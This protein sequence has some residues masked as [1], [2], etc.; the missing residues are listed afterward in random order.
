VGSLKEFF[1]KMAAERGA[2]M[3]S[4][5]D[6]DMPRGFAGAKLRR[7]AIEHTLTRRHR[8][9]QSPGKGGGVNTPYPQTRQ[10][11]PLDVPRRLHWWRSKYMPH[12]GAQEAARRVRQGLC[13]V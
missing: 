2:F 1:I 12:Q 6:D 10:M 11:T 13:H 4:K 8:D 7:K 3:E 9:G 5:K